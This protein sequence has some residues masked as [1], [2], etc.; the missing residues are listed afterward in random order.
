[1][2]LT[3]NGTGSAWAHRYGNSSAVLESGGERLL[4]DC[5]HTAPKRLE[6]IGLTLRDIDGVFISHLHGDHVYGLEE[7]GFRSFLEY[8]KR[9]VL[10]IAEDLAAPLWETVLAGTMMHMKGRRLSLEDY[11]DVRPLP[12][13]RGIA[14]GPWTVEVHPV[15]HVPN[16]PCYGARIR[17]EK[18]ALGFTCDSL[19][20][21]DPWFYDGTDAVFHDC[22][23]LPY[24]PSTIH[25]HFEQLCAY[26]E[27]FRR[28]THLVHYDESLY[29]LA[30][31]PE[32]KETLE[33]SEMRLVEPFVRMRF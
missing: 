29:E 27:E 17:A 23:F 26:P 10:L 15:R 19:A 8:R 14:L 33:Q 32:W 16:M 11:F 20:D 13:D 4:M 2:L 28:K 9:P 7:F 18:A 3:W 21:A 25:A 1:M 5:G 24:F 12:P 30:R 6:K 22:S 31:E